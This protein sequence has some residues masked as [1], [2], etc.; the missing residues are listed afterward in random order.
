[1]ALCGGGDVASGLGGRWG[2][3]PLV[4]LVVVMV[5]RC[6]FGVVV[7]AVRGLE[8]VRVVCKIK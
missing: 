3:L 5:V 8:L 6:G 2:S 4:L 1:M 7:V